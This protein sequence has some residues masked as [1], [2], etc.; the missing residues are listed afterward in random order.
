[1]K[2]LALIIFFS[3]S[4]L[5]GLPTTEELLSMVRK[6]SREEAAEA[7][8]ETFNTYFFGSGEERAKISRAIRDFR[9]KYG[10]SPLDFSVVIK[11]GPE[12]VAVVAGP[13]APQPDEEDLKREIARLQKRVRDQQKLVQEQ[14]ERIEELEEKVKKKSKEAEEI[15]EERSTQAGDYITLGFLQAQE[16]AEA[17]EKIRDLEGQLA[18][19]RREEARLGKRRSAEDCEEEL[20][21]LHD[22]NQDLKSRVRSLERGEGSSSGATR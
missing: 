2:K 17:Q 21:H 7:I 13:Q 4:L 1:M 10:I 6:S 3:G 8:R 12:V 18:E 14:K 9:R 11:K 15:A 16:L 22:E 5:I 20:R 19:S